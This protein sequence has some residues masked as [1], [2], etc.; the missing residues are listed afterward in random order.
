M[1]CSVIG[2]IVTLTLSLLGAPLATEAQ[3][4]EK[5]PRVGYLSDDSGSLGFAPVECPAKGLRPLGYLEGLHIVFE[6][7]YAEGKTDVLPGLTAALVHSK[8]DVIVA[9]GTPA[10]QAAQHA[11]KT[12][13]IV[14]LMGEPV[15]M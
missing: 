5:V 3:P 1:W 13:P 9:Y 2:C 7:R 11:T 6:P 12:I 15:E 10:A 14:A 4:L 8:V